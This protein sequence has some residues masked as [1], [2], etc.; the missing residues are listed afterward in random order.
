MLA[1]H[2]LADRVR[3]LGLRSDVHHLLWACDLLIAPTRYEAY[4]LAVHEALCCARS[5]FVPRAAGVSE[6]YP[7]ALQHLLLSRP[8]DVED[9]VRR[10][11][12]WREDPTA[13]EAPLQQLADQLR[14]CSWSHVAEQ[15]AS[16]IEEAY[17]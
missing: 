17:S 9:L 8:D 11:R 1:Q 3:F 10:L 7:A 12:C 6:R 4:G 14:C 16:L 13:D 15:M 2:N 5:A